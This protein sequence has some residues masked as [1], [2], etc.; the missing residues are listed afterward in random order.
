ML[1]QLPLAPR[2]TMPPLAVALCL[3]LIYLLP[4][5][6]VFALSYEKPLIDAGQWWRLATGQFVHLSFPH[7][8]LN[9]SGLL[10]FWLL[11]AEHASGARYFAIVFIIAL[12]AS[13]GM[14]V[15]DQQIIYYVGF[16]GA[17]Y[18]LF[19]WGALHDVL[20]R[21]ALG[22]LLFIGVVAKASYDYLVVGSGLMTETVSA[23]ESSLAVSAH[24]YGVLT[25]ILLAFGQY[26]W[27]RTK[28]Q[29]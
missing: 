19:A 12:G 8:L 24:F 25:G 4:E 3:L 26:L 29:E 22:W 1:K 7:L 11:F 9:L 23:D 14:Y 6:F 21:V 17:L 5:A 28:S 16:S 10:L 2:F 20:N 15:T 18:G 13:L 27:A